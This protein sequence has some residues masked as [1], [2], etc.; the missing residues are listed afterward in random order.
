MEARPSAAVSPALLA[1]HRG[2]AL[3]GAVVIVA[4]EGWDSDTPDVFQ[5]VLARLRRR[6]E[7]LVWLNL[8][9]TH[10]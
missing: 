3:R 4:S 6:A 8:R 10:S 7:L 2:N 1:S 5:H 9:A